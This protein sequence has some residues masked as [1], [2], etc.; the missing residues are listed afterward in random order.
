M[1]RARRSTVAATRS[2]AKEAVAEEAA[3]A[4]AQLHQV[5]GVLADA[6]G[7]ITGAFETLRAQSDGQ[8]RLM[9]GLMSSMAQQPA[10]DGAPGA[11]RRVS[12]QSF[13]REAG[14]A[15]QSF[16]SVLVSVSEESARTVRRIDQMAEQFDAIFKRVG[17]INDISE[18]TFVLAVNASIQAAHAKATGGQSFAVIAANVR[19]LSR[20]SQEFNREIGEEIEKARHTIAGARQSMC[21]LASRDLNVALESQKRVEQMLDD[22]T[23]FEVLTQQTIERANGTAVQIAGAASEAITAMQFEDIVEQIL[24]NV[25]RRV[26]RLA[27]L[28]RSG[29][30]PAGLADS[31]APVRDPVQQA[32]VSPGD[33]ELF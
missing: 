21:E 20:K 9:E 7:K 22:I 28:S 32:S 15:L 12:V 13:A 26:E 17:Q 23:A 27:V 18:A 24:T 1:S 33:V 16:A 2:A 5:R 3:K 11:Q 30:V 8:R 29:A 25:Q 19:D 14:A 6:V 31:P 10:G 4:S